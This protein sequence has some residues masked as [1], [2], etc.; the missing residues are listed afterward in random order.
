MFNLALI[1]LTLKLATFIFI[2]KNT[3]KYLVLQAI[4]VSVPSIDGRD[5]G[6]VVGVGLKPAPTLPT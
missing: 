5:K 2:D 4:L 6:R 1:E 3:H